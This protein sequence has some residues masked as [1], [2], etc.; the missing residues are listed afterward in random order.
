MFRMVP[1]EKRMANYVVSWWMKK[2]IT[3]MIDRSHP[4]TQQTTNPISLVWKEH[5]QVFSISSLIWA[6]ESS[7]F[8]LKKGTD[9]FYYDSLPILFPIII[10]L[11]FNV[12]KKLFDISKPNSL[13]KFVQI[14]SSWF[15]YFRIRG[16]AKHSIALILFRSYSC[17]VFLRK[18]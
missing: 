13:L 18:S 2:L 10:K 1:T 5:L 7:S 12:S 9:Y 15:L 17:R 14:S 8:L 16:W 3:L 6:Y 11:C 4:M